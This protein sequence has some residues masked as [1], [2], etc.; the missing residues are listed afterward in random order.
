MLMIK[1]QKVHSVFSKVI[2][3]V[4]LNVA[5]AY[6][7]AVFSSYFCSFHLRVIDDTS[8]KQ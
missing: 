6:K 2:I 7:H 4:F 1:L 3:V 5:K 8:L